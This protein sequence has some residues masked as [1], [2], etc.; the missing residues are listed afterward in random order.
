MGGHY[1]VNVE[2]VRTMRNS[3]NYELFFKAMG[4][5]DDMVNGNHPTTTITNEEM[6]IICH[7]YRWKLGRE[8]ANYQNVPEYIY[9]TFLTFTKRKNQVILNSWMLDY[10]VDPKLNSLLMNDLKRF[11]HM[12]SES[13]SVNISHSSVNIF[14]T[15]IFAIFDNLQNILL[16]TTNVA[17][18]GAYRLSFGGLLSII[19]GA[20]FKQ[21]TIKATCNRS[22]E[23]SWL[24][25][26]FEEDWLSVELAQQYN[27]CGLRI[28]LGESIKNTRGLKDDCVIILNQSC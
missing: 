14:C 6:E 27:Q 13:S 22:L 26:F 5:F 7:L 9:Q 15:E 25:V 4:H 28:Y 1:K 10:R 8:K 21:I 12:E 17:G 19:K 24:R 23:R 16:Y 18:I 11:S 2:S 3:N 20:Q